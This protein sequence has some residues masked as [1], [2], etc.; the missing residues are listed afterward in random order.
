[1][2]QDDFHLVTDD[3]GRLG[4]IADAAIAAMRPAPVASAPADERALT[5]QQRKEFIRRTSYISEADRD[6]RAAFVDEI[7]RAALASAPVAGE[8]QTALNEWFDK[9][10]FIQKRIAS[11]DLPV[12]Y[13]GW[14]RADV[15]RDLIDAAARNQV[16]PSGCIL[17]QEAD[18]IPHTHPEYGPG[19]FFTEDA[20]IEFDAAPQASEAAD[21]LTIDLD[22]ADGASVQIEVHGTER[23]LRRLE[24]W[25]GGERS[26]IRE[27]SRNAALEEAATFLE[28]NRT[29]W[30]S[31][32]AAYEIRALKQPQAATGGG[33]NTVNG[34]EFSEFA[35]SENAGSGDC[36][37]GA[38]DEAMRDALEMLIREAQAVADDHHR[39]RY[40]RLDEAIQSA[41]AALS[42][43]QTEQG[44]RDE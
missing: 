5:A 23:M 30:Q 26:R 15:M 44:E 42:A 29:A 25:L 19:I 22:Y 36:A 16:L 18:T 34:K 33:A 32:R 28:N 4:E 6:T 39:P 7:A 2:S 37:M 20:R 21:T 35:N 14:H 10:D 31:V 43:T 11:G 27:Q 8:A 38:G 13:L 3:A 24:A 1:M 17:V 12:M 40:T 9:T 41:R